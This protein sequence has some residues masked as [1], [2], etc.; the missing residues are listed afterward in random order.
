MRRS[1][2]LTLA[3]T[4][5]AP[6]LLAQSPP[7]RPKLPAD[8]DTNDAQ[9][10]YDYGVQPNVDWKKTHDADYWAW[11]LEPYDTGYLYAMYLALWYRQPAQWREEHDAGA[12]YVV[13]SKEAR[14]IDSVF[15][16]LLMRDP[17]PHLR[18]SCLF[19]EE[20]DRDQDKVYVGLVHYQYHCYDQAN[21]AFGKAL[22]KDPSLL[23]LHMYRARGFFYR[24]HYDSTAVVLN[25][26][27]DSL[28]ARD[29]AYLTQTYNS[30]AMLEYM[31]GIAETRRRNWDGAR[32]ALGR[33]LTEDLAFYP[34]HA[35]LARLELNLN[36]PTAAITEYELAVGLKGDDGVL[37]HEY[38]YALLENDR[39]ADAETQLREAIRLEPY[40]AL[41]HFNLAVALASQGKREL[42][43]SEYE[44]F[45]AR[46]PKR[47]GS[48]AAD[49]R[50]RI[51]RL[52]G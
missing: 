16:E 10:Y 7:R 30:K 52:R 21:A 11:R 8:A 13:K 18:Y 20:L 22:T 33:A 29:L 9:A 32:V 3:A 42:A 17:F 19:D 39:D 26:L 43:V 24:Q 31:V 4:L 45:I 34:A 6:A 49:A 37:R 27:L 46:C 50:S 35:A 15:T 36:N 40:W 44:A 28:R 5:V 41:P 51:E 38:G 48:Q 25:I 1:T 14:Q 47:L 12:S 2:L 23:F